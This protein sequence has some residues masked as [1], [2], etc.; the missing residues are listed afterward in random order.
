MLSDVRTTLRTWLKGKT[1]KEASNGP[2][3]L[4][5]D[6]RREGIVIKPVQELYAEFG[7]RSQRV[8]LKQRSPEYL[9]AE[10]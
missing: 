5:P 9:N 2:S 3:T 4:K 6:V 8:I 7:G 10:E 1:I